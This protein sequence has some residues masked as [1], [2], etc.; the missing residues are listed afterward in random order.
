LIS[1][2]AEETIQIRSPENLL[3]HRGELAESK[4]S[5]CSIDPSLDQNELAQKRA[6]NQGDV[7]KVEDQTDRSSIIRK[8]GR[9][10]VGNVMH[11]SLV[12]ELSFQEANDLHTID[13][14]DIDPRRR[15]HLEKLQ[16]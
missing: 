2:D 6:R 3:E 5:P 15:R 4:F 7:G 10:L 1:I 13:F 11:R 16:G 9:D 12:E 14:V 8:N